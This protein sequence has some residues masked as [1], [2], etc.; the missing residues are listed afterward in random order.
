MRLEMK[1]T[2]HATNGNINDVAGSVKGRVFKWG[3]GAGKCEMR[4]YF[5]RWENEFGFTVLR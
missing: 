5:W 4:K 3:A 2:N 1:L